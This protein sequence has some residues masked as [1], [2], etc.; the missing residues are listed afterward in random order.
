MNR[1]TLTLIGVVTALAAVTGVGALTVPDDGADDGASAAQR[2]PVERSTLVCPKPSESELATTDYTAFTP[3]G[4]A[5]DGKGG[6]RLLP[7]DLADPSTPGGDDKKDKKDK[8]KDEDKGE[9]GGSAKS[10][11]PLKAP[12]TPVVT[13]TDSPDAPALFG[14]ADGSFAPGWTVQQTTSVSAGIGRGL[15]GT[16]CGEADTDFWF[17]AAS[18]ADE[19]HDYAHLTNPDDTAAVVDLEMY[20]K[21]GRV[22][23]ESGREITVPPRSTVPVL[24]STLTPDPETN[25]AV[26]AVVRTGRVG[27]QVHAVDDDLGGDWLPAA[28]VPRGTAVLPGIPADATAVRLV[29]L[30]TGQDDADLKVRLAGRS[31]QIT[32]AGHET[33]HLKPGEVNAVDLGDV[34]KGEPGSLVLTP[35]EKGDTTPFV[36]ALRVTRG[37]GAK[38]ETAFIPATVPVEE[39]ATVADNRSK[40]GTLSLTAPGEAAT[41]KVTASAGSGGGSP[42]T[43]TYAVK[44]GTT[45]AVTP[46]LPTGGK[47]TYALTVERESGGEV[48]A[49]R[50][51]EVKAD[52]VPAFTVQTLPDDRG[53]VAV[54]EAGQDLSVLTD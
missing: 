32:P 25:L 11:L 44:A 3:K 29:A 31:G 51:L 49:A 10:V 20:G 26:H 16:A 7:A 21:G 54:P 4:E 52:G 23:S 27:A 42:K 53:T 18:T 48:Y 22:T 15:H 13:D 5:G 41:V 9:D 19:R 43:A 46:P 36:A 34:T 35:S 28:G 17:P 33:L 6:A 24:L 30:T 45:T 12:G 47:G 37:K 14:S 40:G 8:K 1:T 39:R 38:Q 2:L 50:T